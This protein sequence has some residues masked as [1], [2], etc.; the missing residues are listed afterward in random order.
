MR[1]RSPSAPSGLWRLASASEAR[2][3]ASHRRRRRRYGHE[4][5]P[6]DSARRPISHRPTPVT[7]VAP[8]LSGSYR[9]LWIDPLS[10]KCM[11][12]GPKNPNGGGHCHE[13]KGKSIEG[14]WRVATGRP[15]CRAGFV[16]HAATTTASALAV[17][18]SYRDT[19]GRRS[20]RKKVTDMAPDHDAGW[21]IRPTELQY[22]STK[23]GDGH[24][25]YPYSQ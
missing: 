4:R 1:C 2:G 3:R 19:H 22:Y 17:L 7:P 5:C 18:L 9:N 24:C 11:A 20:R 8:S 13:G 15:T 23:H 14:M 21:M 6:V 10:E 16:R 12:D 25:T